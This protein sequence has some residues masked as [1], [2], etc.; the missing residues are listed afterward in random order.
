[1]VEIGKRD[2]IGFGKLDMNNFLA[3]RSYC[4]V[5]ADAFR[6]TPALVH[7]YYMQIID[8][9][10]SGRI[11]PI[12][13]VKAFDAVSSYDAFRH[14]Q[15]G[16]H[17]GRICLSIHQPGK[18]AEYDAVVLDRPESLDLSGSACYLL[19]GGLGGLGR[20]ISTWMIIME[21]EFDISVSKCGSGPN[22]AQ[23]IHELESMKAFGEAK[24]PIKGILQMSMVLNDEGFSK[25]TPEQWNT[26][27]R[28]KVHGTWNLNNAS[29]SA[30][31]D[32]DFFV[33]FSSLSGI[34]GQ[35]GQANYASA[36]TFLDSFIQYRVNLGLPA[37]TI[38]IGAVGD[39][40]FISQDRELL[41]KM[42][43]TGFMALK[44]QEVLDG[45]LVAMTRKPTK[46]K[47][48]RS[49]SSQFV[50]Y[51][52]FVLGLGSTVPLDSPTNRSVSRRDR[53]M[54]IYHNNGGATA[55]SM[56]SNACLKTYIAGAKA[57]VSL[58]SKQMEPRHSLPV[59]LARGYSRFS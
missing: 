28:P 19:V 3:N 26:A 17:I 31:L 24:Q 50:D 41:Q 8:H 59:R 4:C 49:R 14:M 6:Q 37:S 23:F 55:D 29:I 15:P 39:V 42:T 51:N 20:A 13:P 53:R 52:N 10:Q 35:P 27:T 36:N 54:A 45:L 57:D 33:L 9:F 21:P 12:R 43:S 7:K 40:G 38:D 25:M 46:N 2:L 34:I 56:T 5:D 16:Q 1:M 47:E 18:Q 58:F 32:L 30:E 11:S 48:C 22:D 44:E